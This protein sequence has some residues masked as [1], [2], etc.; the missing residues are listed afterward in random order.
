MEPNTNRFAGKIALVTGA[1]S[2]IGRAIAARLVAEG[3]RVVGGD[4]NEHGLNQLA[5]ELG[6]SFAF[7][8][9][10]VTA[11]ADGEALVALAVDRFG[12][13]DLAFNVAGGSRPGYLLDLSEDD[14]QWTIDLCL[15]GVFL[16]VKHQ[17]RQMV[18]GG[19]G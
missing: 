11:E 12:G 16:G 17:A 5:H 3:A 13:L 10:D 14:W 9:A 4:R 19:K 8:L 2:G 15:K 18:R 1:A 7:A 6:D